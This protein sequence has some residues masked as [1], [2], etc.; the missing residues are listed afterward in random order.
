[1]NEIEIDFKVIDNLYQEEFRELELKEKLLTQKKKDKVLHM[2]LELK[3]KKY[4]LKN[5]I[6]LSVQR[7]EECSGYPVTYNY[8]YHY[9]LSDVVH[10]KR[11]EISE[12]S[13]NKLKPYLETKRV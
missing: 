7:T 10:S 4:K 11:Y 12:S 6:L 5:C 8:F 3:G 9:Y 2:T 13:Y 1:M